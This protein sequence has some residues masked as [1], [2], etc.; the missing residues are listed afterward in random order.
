MI[1]SENGLLEVS[2]LL[3][4]RGRD[5]GSVIADAERVIRDKIK[6]RPVTTT[7]GAAV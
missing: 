6:M 5:P 4:A 1:N 2:V 3:N 7:A